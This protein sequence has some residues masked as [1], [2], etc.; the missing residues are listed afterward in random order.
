VAYYDRAVIYNTSYFGPNSGWNDVAAI[1]KLIQKGKTSAQFDFLVL[2][3]LDPVALY[4]AA[5]QSTGE[6]VEVKE[7]LQLIIYG[8]AQTE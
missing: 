2:F 8:E 3:S 1:A 7:P 6:P 5:T 4:D